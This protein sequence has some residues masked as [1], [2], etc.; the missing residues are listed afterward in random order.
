ME[1]IIVDA[2]NSDFPEDSTSLLGQGLFAYHFPLRRIDSV[3][4]LLLLLGR[5]PHR[6]RSCRFSTDRPSVHCFGD[7]VLRYFW[8]AVSGSGCC[9]ASASCAHTNTCRHKLFASFAAISQLI[10]V[11]VCGC[12][13]WL[14]FLFSVRWGFRI[15]VFGWGKKRKIF[16]AFN[17]VNVDKFV[18]IVLVQFSNFWSSSIIY[19][20]FFGSV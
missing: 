7:G 9:H 10:D 14:L 15:A 2:A 12:V 19:G 4:L 6:N 18:L 3:K 13:C 17:N 16:T 8:L 1:S 11:C 5:Q 20:F